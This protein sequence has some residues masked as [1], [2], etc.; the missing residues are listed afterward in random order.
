[1]DEKMRFYL[2]VDNLHTLGPFRT[3]RD[4]VIV[5]CTCGDDPDVR[6]VV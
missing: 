1:M 2:A 3:R 6:G 5:T 4:V